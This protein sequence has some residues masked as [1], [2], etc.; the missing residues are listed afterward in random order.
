MLPQSFIEELKYRS[1]I[2]SVISSYV[3]LKRAGR[4]YKGLCPFH[5]EKSP[6]FTIY[7]ES[8]SFYCYGCGK[9]GDVVTFIKNIENLEYIEAIKFLAE[10]AGIAV[11]EEGADDSVAR[12]KQE[13]LS[14]NKDTARFYHENLKTEHGKKAL[15]YLMERGLSGKTIGKF[16]LGFAPDSW[17]SL[18]KYLTA[19]GYS[20]YILASAGLVTKNKKNNY[21]DSFRNRIIFPIIDLRGNV[22][23]FGGRN[24]GEYGPKYLNSPDTPVFKKSRNL[25]AL[26]IAKNSKQEG[27]IL[28][29]GYMDVIAL[30]QAGFTE[31]VATLGTALTSE[32][33][34]II[35]G[36]S[37]KVW[38][39]YD[40]DE[41]GQKATHRAI[42]ILEDT[43]VNIKVV[44]ITGAK[45][46]DEYIKKFGATRFKLLLEG[47]ASS[48]DYEIAKLKNKY[49][50][51]TNE[52]KVN[53]IK[54]V[55]EYLASLESP[56]ERDIYISKISAELNIDKQAVKEQVASAIKKK[57]KTQR[58]K[59]NRNLRVFDDTSRNN[60]DINREKNM[61]YAIAE[62]KL[63][64]A[65]MKNPDYYDKLKGIIT[66]ENIVTDKN[67]EIFAKLYNRLEEGLSIGLIDISGELEEN[68]LSHLSRILAQES[69]METNAE[70]ALSYAQT[71]LNFD[72]L[73]SKDEI[74]KANNEDLNKYIQGLQK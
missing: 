45:D 40:A 38:I 30:H 46:P 2:E 29:E 43:G 28:A 15:T 49:N 24:M 42:S 54:E 17:D 18:Y 74:L 25:F 35:S 26:N 34:R 65:L 7:P 3:N 12:L 14:A 11:P 32:Q 10:K 48:S 72:K 63:I 5:S 22:I 8:G 57:V 41:A 19:K 4:M 51:E 69:E 55:T 13:I 61:K 73:S 67:R 37:K 53:F 64:G 39:A 60:R 56:V 47:S 66:A 59:E 23:A 31:A 20:D 36:Y 44:T 62:D 16:G 70:Q 68:I 1:N 50:T 9:G 58:Y 71:I 6:S 52:G 27:M 33:S 21:Y